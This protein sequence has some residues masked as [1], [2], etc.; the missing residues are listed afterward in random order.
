MRSWHGRYREATAAVRQAYG[1]IARTY[2]GGAGQPTPE[3]CTA[4][5]R[6]VADLLGERA[7]ALGAPELGVANQLR[8]VYQQLGA[9][10]ASCEAG[11]GIEA[12]GLYGQV[13]A[14][15]QRAAAALA[16]WGLQP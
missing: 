1:P 13:G 5:R 7:E 8:T 16:P 2:S 6:A 3:Q 14:Q 9:L 12:V 10:A 15:L 4:L 11:R